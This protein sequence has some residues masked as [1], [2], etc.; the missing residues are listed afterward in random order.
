MLSPTKIFPIAGEKHKISLVADEV[1]EINSIA[2]EV[3]GSSPVLKERSIEK[4]RGLADA[5]EPLSP[6]VA[7]SLLYQAPE[8][9]DSRALPI[10]LRHV[11]ETETCF[12]MTLSLEPMT[13]ISN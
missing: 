10:F 8:S 12:S 5:M 13:G 2:D 11:L 9:Q 7:T 3:P 6:G 1:P 4:P